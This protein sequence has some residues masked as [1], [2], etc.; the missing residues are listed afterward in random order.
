MS[1]RYKLLSSKDLLEKY[2]PIIIKGCKKTRYCSFD[3]ETNGEQVPS[4]TFF[5]TLLGISY[6]PGLSFIIPLGHNESPIKKDWFKYLRQISKEILM[7][8]SIVKI[9]HN[10]KY[11]IKCLHRF[12]L[13]YEGFMFDTMLAKYLLKEERPHGLGEIVKEVFPEFSSYKDDTEKLAKKHGWANIPL[14]ELSDRC[15]LDTDLTLRLAIY[16]EPKLIEN[17]FYKLFR[18]LLV[19]DTKVLAESELYGMPLDL[20]HLKALDKKYTSQLIKL[21]EKLRKKKRVTKYQA[22]RLKSLKSKYIAQLK[23]ELNEKKKRGASALTIKNTENKISQILAGSFTTKKDQKLFEPINFAS[24]DQLK[25]LLFY[26]KKGFKFDIVKYTKDKNNKTLTE[27]ASTD[28][29]TLLQ[30]QKIDKSGFIKGLLEFRGLKTLHGTFV[31]GQLER[32]VN[33]TAYASF[34]LHGTVTGRLSS[35]DPNLQNIPRTTTNPD[36][37]RAFLPPAGYALLEV[38]YSQAELRIV[39][40]LSEDPTMIDIFARNYNI[41]VATACRVYKE[42]DR[43]DEIKKIIKIGEAMEAHEL[44]KPENKDYLFW[45][46]AKKQAKTINFGILYGQGP[47]KLAEGMGVS[48]EA[49]KEFI[50]LWFKAYPEVEKWISKQQKYAQKHGYVYNLF[51][52]KRRLPDALLSEAQAK[53]YD[54]SGKRAEALRQSVNAPIQGGSSDICQLAAVEIYE[55]RFQ[56]KLPFYMRQLYTVHDSL[57]Y[58]ILPEDIHSVIPKIIDICSNPNIEEWFGFKMKHVNMKVSPEIG[59]HWADLEEYNPE[60]DYSTLQLLH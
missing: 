14:K 11:E 28:E 51:G 10:C 39:A 54:L 15:A 23:D 8:P 2:I 27:N 41:H 20:N 18:N 58:P 7:D 29:E 33:S 59:V 52:R 12:G 44:Q 31:K 30:L 26:S 1:H 13:D 46:K 19:P 50:K 48:V 32:Q 21:D 4:K 6:Q 24:P 17:K 5:I 56:G 35:K 16:F 60:K 40:E 57:G 45:V 9:A 49:A 37:K 25:D 55:E 3:F 43:Y 42:L 36:I 22:Y 47:A 34:L 38:D 53:K